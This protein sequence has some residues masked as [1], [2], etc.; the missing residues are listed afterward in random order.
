MPSRATSGAAVW[1]VRCSV[2]TYTAAMRSPVSISRCATEFRLFLTPGGER[3]VAVPVDQT[4]R[5]TLDVGYG[6]AVAH[7]QD[8]GGARRRG[9]SGLRELARFGHGV[10]LPHPAQP[11]LCRASADPALQRSDTN[12]SEHHDGAGRLAG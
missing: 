5:L 11:R 12:G 6:L 2:V 9:E 8:L 7:Q 1:C 10:T 3:R 4:E